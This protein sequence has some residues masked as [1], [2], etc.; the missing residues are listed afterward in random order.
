MTTAAVR[1]RLNT[2]RSGRYYEGRAEL[3]LAGAGFWVMRSPGSKGCADLVAIG[4][5]GAPILLCQ[6]KGRG[7]RI[8]PGEWNALLTLARSLGAV[9]LLV[10]F[11]TPGR[12]RCRELLA[13]R[14]GDRTR[15][16]LRDYPLTAA[17]A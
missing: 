6:V 11:P 5:G 7:S 16:P 10:D 9:P 4:P 17:G 14:T 8:R 15:L 3:A 1:P 12:A 13:P 2:A